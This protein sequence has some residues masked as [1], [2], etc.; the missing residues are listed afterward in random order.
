MILIL[1][2]LIPNIILT[3]TIIITGASPREED[4]VV[5]VDVAGKGVVGGH[6]VQVQNAPVARVVVVL[7]AVGDVH[8][9]HQR[10]LVVQVP[11]GRGAESCESPEDS[12]ES[13]GVI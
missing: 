8:G 9:R 3:I 6:I 1:H 12:Q 10:P 2:L 4:G 11:A 5:W 13:L 7:P